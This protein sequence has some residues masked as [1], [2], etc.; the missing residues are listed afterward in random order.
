MNVFF[1][2]YCISEFKATCDY[3]RNK[4][5][6]TAPETN[7]L[8]VDPS[9]W[10]PTDKMGTNVNSPISE[11]QS[12]ESIQAINSTDSKAKIY[13]ANDWLPTVFSHVKIWIKDYF[14]QTQQH[15]I[16]E[17]LIIIIAIILFVAYK[18]SMTNEQPRRKKRRKPN[19]DRGR[20]TRNKSRNTSQNIEST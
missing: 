11:P 20:R 18:M 1:T 17:I 16:N 7:T 12:T 19:N 13:E 5:M 15:V 9:K 2:D 14:Q 10:K 6:F 3:V 4:P 8:V